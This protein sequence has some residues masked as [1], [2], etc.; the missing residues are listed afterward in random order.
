MQACHK[1][2]GTVIQCR[3]L[4]E[5]FDLGGEK[6]CGSSTGAIDFPLDMDRTGW[7]CWQGPTEENAAFF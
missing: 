4:E 7:N 3:M 5:V 2:R 1:G 6:G